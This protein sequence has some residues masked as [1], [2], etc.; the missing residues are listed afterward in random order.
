MGGSEADRGP[1]PRALPAFHLLTRGPQQIQSRRLPEPETPLSCGL[2]HAGLGWRSTRGFHPP[3][4]SRGEKAGGAYTSETPVPRPAPTSLS[5][6]SHV[7]S[8]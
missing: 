5:Q 8:N 2:F 4:K 7:T 1:R 3:W 6:G